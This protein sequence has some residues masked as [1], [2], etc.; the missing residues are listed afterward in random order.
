MHHWPVCVGVHQSGDM[1]GSV[2]YMSIYGDN[3]CNLTVIACRKFPKVK[4][5]TGGRLEGNSSS[6]LDR[7]SED[8]TTP[9]PLTL[10]WTHI[11]L[12]EDPNLHRVMVVVS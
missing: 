8:I 5:P 1:I 2:L 6:W 3:Q 7:R 9:S 4:T 10:R 11:E 12:P